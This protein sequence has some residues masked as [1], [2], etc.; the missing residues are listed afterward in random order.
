MRFKPIQ[1]FLNVRLGRQK[2]SFLIKPRLIEI[3]TRIHQQR[4]L[5]CQTSPD[6][7]DATRRIIAGRRCQTLDR[8]DMPG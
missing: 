6:G 8:I 3:A 5:S 2:C 1:L 4:Y 7:F